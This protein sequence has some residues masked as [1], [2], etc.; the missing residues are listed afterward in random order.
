MGTKHACGIHTYIHTYIHAGKCSHTQN[1]IFL[2]EVSATL[3][4][5][6][7]CEAAESISYKPTSEGLWR[8]LQPPCPPTQA[9]SPVK[10]LC[11]L[12]ENDIP[13]LVSRVTGLQQ[14]T[15]WSRNKAKQH[16]HPHFSLHLR[17][18]KGYY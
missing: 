7:N 11:T 14:A 15:K 16:P 9:L 8:A 18:L 1:K 5:R 10:G 6:K 2:A 17:Y 12:A 3:S 13:T 4:V